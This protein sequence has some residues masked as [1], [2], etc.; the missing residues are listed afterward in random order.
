MQQEYVIRVNEH[1]RLPA[2]DS[3]TKIDLFTFLA[4]TF[5]I[6]SKWPRKALNSEQ[7]LE[8]EFK[9][10][11]KYCTRVLGEMNENLAKEEVVFLG[12]DPSI[13]KEFCWKHYYSHSQGHYVKREQKR[14]N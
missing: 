8:E 5:Y 4:N 7:E 2:K 6:D 12:T 3:Y 1:Y 9:K 14:R 13:N 10:Y 11:E